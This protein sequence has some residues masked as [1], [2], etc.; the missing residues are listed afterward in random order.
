MEVDDRSFPQRA[1][2]DT[3]KP[4]PTTE[5]TQRADGPNFFRDGEN[6][7]FMRAD[8]ILGHNFSEDDGVLHLRVRTSHQTHRTA[9]TH[10]SVMHQFVTEEDSWGEMNFKISFVTPQILRVKFAGKAGTLDAL[11]DNP[12]FPPPEARMLNGIPQNIKADLVVNGDELVLKSA[13]VELRAQTSPFRLR[14][15]RRG[16]S[17]PFWKQRVS[18]LFTSDIIPTSIVA[19][20]GR[21]AT[22][23]AFSLD[24]QERIFGLG[25][26]F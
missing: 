19:H 25:E 23:D 1:T 3:S 26:R 24:P 20:Q 15:Y 13:A 2:G 5:A 10:N 16:C 6:V 18:D 21:E 7:Q 22:F 12:L 11:T 17:T 4:N 9:Q 8:S 14:A